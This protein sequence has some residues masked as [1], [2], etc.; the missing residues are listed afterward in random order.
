MSE[1]LAWITPSA[2]DVA[3]TDEEALQILQRRGAA[4]QAGTSTFSASPQ[5]RSRA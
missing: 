2:R 3:E 4:S 1:K 5:S